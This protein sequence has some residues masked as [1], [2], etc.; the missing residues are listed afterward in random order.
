MQIKSRALRMMFIVGM[1]LGILTAPGGAAQETTEA[2]LPRSFQGARLGMALSDLVAIAPDANRV[3]LGR[4]DP[5]QRTVVVP[6]KDRYLRRIEYRFYNDHL[7][8]LAIHYHSNEVPGG[9]QRLL[10]RLT[11]AYGKPIVLDEQ[12]GYGLVRKTVWK[13][14]ATRSSL[15]ES[16]KLI[17]DKR[18]LILTI[19]DLALQQAFEE[20]QEHRRRQ[21]ELS[22]PIPLPDH[23][24]ENRQAVV[25]QS[26][27]LHH[28]RTDG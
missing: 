4:R 3:S 26:D 25:S 2:A 9:Y 15:V 24:I 6:S 11:E 1:L 10:E 7:R 27:Q 16:R 14:R 8:E 13:D 19:T 23:S 28:G 12:E 17:D 21:R 5:F 22:I 20:D 18:E